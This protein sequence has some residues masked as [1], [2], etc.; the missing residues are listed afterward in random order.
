MFGFGKNKKTLKNKD[1]NINKLQEEQSKVSFLQKLKNG[2]KKTRSG[3]TNGL[4]QKL[5][6]YSP[7]DEE[8]WEELRSR[9]IAA[10]CGIEVVEL[11]ITN[12]KTK[13]R[14]NSLSKEDFLPCLEETLCDLLAP[15]NKKFA[16]NNENH[17]TKLILMIGINGSGKTTTMGKLANFLVKNSQKVMFAAGDTFRAA[18]IEQ[19]KIWGERNN[20]PVI[21]QQHGADSGAVIF[22]AYQSAIAK[23]YNFVIADTAGRLHT[24][25]NLMQEL[26]KI[27]RV[28]KKIDANAPH[29]TLLVIDA[30]LGQNSLQQAK[31]FAQ[32]VNVSGICLTKLDG[33]AKGGIAFAIA[34]KL[35]LPIYFIGIGEQI[36]DMQQFNNKEFVKALL[37]DD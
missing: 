35:Q 17:K 13:F 3:L 7:I 18:A 4:L 20:I 34:H 11:V 16:L 24:Q 21:S 32:E 15:C 33:T 19:L 6:L 30:T 8:L 10:D 9:L 12:M 14:Q 23:N 31:I 37:S 22:D 26:K 28:A 27:S 36:D 1:E 5:K 25:S 2:L 29:E